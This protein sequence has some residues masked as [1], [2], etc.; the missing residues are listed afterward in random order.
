[1]EKI[2][3]ASLWHITPIDIG[4]DFY[5]PTISTF[6]ID[7]ETYA[8]VSP[9]NKNKMPNYYSH[10]DIVVLNKLRKFNSD[11]VNLL[12]KT[13]TNVINKFAYIE[14]FPEIKDCFCCFKFSE[15]LFLHF[16]TNG[17]TQQT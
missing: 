9:Q 14:N 1:M 13:K 6:T 7:Y 5:N 11:F 15:N 12:K 3:K 17:I 8:L 16:L 10:S 4:I 2:R